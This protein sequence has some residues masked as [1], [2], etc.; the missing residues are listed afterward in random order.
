MIIYPAIDLHGGHVVR[1]REGDPSKQTVFSHQPVDM[2]QQWIDQ[3][4]EWLHVVNLD[5]AFAKANDN[6]AILAQIAALGI[7]VQF[8]GGLR[9]L[10]DMAKALKQG[11]SRIVLGTVAID[12]PAMVHEALAKFGAD[13][14]CVALD[15]RDGFVTT[16]GWTNAS[17]QTPIS[18]GR[19]MA[20]AGVIH[21]LYT[22]VKRDGSLI[23]SNVHDTIS[24]ARNTDLKVIAS[25]GVSSMSEISQLAQSGVVAGAIIGMAL[26]TGELTLKEALIAAKDTRE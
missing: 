6:S 18:L 4:A 2:A 15:S 3:G 10:D 11:A 5:G 1:L 24:L 21:A 23:G 16:H 9:S 25:G 14:I 19:S 26:Y 8:G 22:D 20:E 13:K 7:P 17:D 12:N